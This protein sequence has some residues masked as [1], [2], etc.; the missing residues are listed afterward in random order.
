MNETICLSDLHLWNYF[1]I[2]AVSVFAEFL[3]GG[4]FV[5]RFAHRR[6]DYPYLGQR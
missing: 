3:K 1:G 6:N 2:S 5:C 4:C